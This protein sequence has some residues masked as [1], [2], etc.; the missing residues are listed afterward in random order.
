M[1]IKMV[2]CIQKHNN[3]FTHLPQE[4]ILF[5]YHFEVRLILVSVFL[6]C[7]DGSALT[8]ENTRIFSMEYESVHN[9]AGFLSPS[10]WFLSH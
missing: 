8:I 10:I 7:S 4:S 1:I 6:K 5:Y 9:L 2:L 3:W